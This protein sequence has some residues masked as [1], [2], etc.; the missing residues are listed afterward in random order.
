MGRKV[1][2]AGYTGSLSSPKQAQ[3]N[4]LV[5]VYNTS[6]KVLTFKVEFEVAGLNVRKRFL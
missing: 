4:G 3:S 2:H 6:K 1:K 5:M